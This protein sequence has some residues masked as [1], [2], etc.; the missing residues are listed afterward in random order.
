MFGLR[1]RVM[2]EILVLSKE[3][4]INITLRTTNDDVELQDLIRQASNAKQ[5]DRLR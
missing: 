2:V 1:S 5:R 3:P 4:A